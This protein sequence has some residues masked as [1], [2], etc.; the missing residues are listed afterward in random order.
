MNALQRRAVKREQKRAGKRI[1]TWARGRCVELGLD[2]D[3]WMTYTLHWPR[4]VLP[5]MQ[6]YN[7]PRK[8]YKA[9]G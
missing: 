1:E 3:R 7:W 5:D 9:R 2:P 8:H 4:H 6:T